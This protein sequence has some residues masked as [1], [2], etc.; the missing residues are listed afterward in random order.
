MIYRL[1]T[2]EVDTSN[3]HLSEKGNTKAVEPKVFDLIVYLINNRERLV[4]R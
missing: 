1:G 4:S 3:F 2:I